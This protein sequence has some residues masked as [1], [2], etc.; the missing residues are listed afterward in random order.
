MGGLQLIA[1]A[2]GAFDNKSE[3]IVI[4]KK[5]TKS[6]EIGSVHEAIEEGSS[7][8]IFDSENNKHIIAQSDIA[9]WE[10]DCYMNEFF[11][12][13]RPYNFQIVY[14]IK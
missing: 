9:Y 6:F 13:I 4:C 3:I 14:G 8:C 12:I 11:E 1:T 2:I 5:N 10:H 7:L